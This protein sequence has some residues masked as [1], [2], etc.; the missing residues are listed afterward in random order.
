MVFQMKVVG[1][2]VCVCVCR[3]EMELSDETQSHLVWRVR[4]KSRMIS[5]WCSCMDGDAFFF[6]NFIFSFFSPKPPGT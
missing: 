4:K 1:V 3:K 2:C 5:T 6:F